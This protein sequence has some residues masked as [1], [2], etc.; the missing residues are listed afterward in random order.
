MLNNKQVIDFLIEFNFDIKLTG[1]GL[2][3][4]NKRL[5][6]KYIDDVYM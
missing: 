4:W 2:I 5:T 1:W 3:L 6:P